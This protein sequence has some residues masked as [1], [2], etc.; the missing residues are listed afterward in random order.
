DG[1]TPLELTID[2]L[3]VGEPVLVD[4]QLRPTDAGHITYLNSVLD[5]PT[6]DTAGQIQRRND[7]TFATTANTAVQASDV[8]AGN[9]DIR[10]IPMLEVAI[11]YTAGHYGNLPVNSAY[12]GTARSPGVSVDAWLD[13][14]ETAPY[15]IVARQDDATSG[16]LTLLVPVSTVYDETGGGEVAFGAQLIYWPSQGVNDRATWGAAHEVRLVWLVQMLTDECVDEGADEDTC[17]RQDVTQI[18]HVYDEEWRLTGMEVSEEHGLDVGIIY[19]E[20]AGDD[21]LALDDEL[22]MASWNLSNTFLRGRDCDTTVNGVCQSNGGRDVTVGT[23]RSEIDE[24]TANDNYLGVLEIPSY[25]HSGYVAHV[26]MTETVDLLASEFAG[27]EARTSPTLL[28]AQ[29]KTQRQ[30]NLDYADRAG[31]AVTFDFDP[32]EVGANTLALLSWGSYKYI[33]G[34]WTNYDSEEY[35]N[36]LAAE[37]ETSS[38]FQAADSSQDS[39][40]E[41]EGKRIWAE[42]YYIALVKGSSNV[43]AAGDETTWTVSSEADYDYEPDWEASPSFKGASYVAGI[44]GS[45]IAMT[46]TKSLFGYKHGYVGFWA[47]FKTEFQ[48]Y[49]SKYTF[50]SSIHS[51]NGRA[52]NATTAVLTVVMVTAVLLYAYGM[53]SGDQ[54]AQDI[55]FYALNGLAVIMTTAYVLT[56]VRTAYSA[57]SAGLALTKVLKFTK[58]TFSIGH[59]V[60][61]II[62]LAATWGP[63]IYQIATGKLSGIAMEFAIA[64]AVAATIMFIIILVLSTLPII[65]L[66]VQLLALVDIILMLMGKQGVQDRVTAWL[67]KRIFTIETVIDNFDDG[68]RL[69]F[70]VTDA[71]LSDPDGGFS[72]DNGLLVTMAITTE[73]HHVDEF[74]DFVHGDFVTPLAKKATLDYYLQRRETDRH[75]GMTLDGDAGD[76][77]KFGKDGDD[78]WIRLNSSASS[79]EAIPFANVGTGL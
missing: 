34:A 44:Y 65:G 1:D 59:I 75:S 7:T 29:E 47:H 68:A 54:W 74:K 33:G 36:A 17:A 13:S 46:L 15:G 61:M 64:G 5:W 66:L 78:H 11:P 2:N 38:F 71:S 49:K 77:D 45:S 3:E 40:D 20:P 48:I 26:M 42:L 6:G 76:W 70:G 63:L 67:A 12:G 30:L 79:T 39:L 69:D 19:E 62:F 31:S 37:L 23:L 32:A 53:L 10:L 28:F 14:A 8:R 52:I 25:E 24:W 35:A 58:T 41:A 51:N 55:A 73:L 60:T 16:D 9:G 18:I 27:Y 57:Y 21:N 22:W 72:V 56:M 50:V 43:V 4:I